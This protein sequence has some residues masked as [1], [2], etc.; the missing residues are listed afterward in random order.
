MD[1]DTRNSQKE[2]SRTNLSSD[3][4]YK[5]PPG[6]RW[7]K[8]GEVCKINPRSPRDF[9]RSLDTPTTFIPMA[10]INE[11]TGTVTGPQ[12]VPY[13]RV[14]KGY[15]YF[16]EGDV[17]FAKITPCMQNGKHVIA[18]NLIDRIGFGTTEF[19]VLRPHN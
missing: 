4:P 7:V 10:A 2:E 3:G 5:L 11:K 1:G 13:Y 8:L 6:W 18:R 14:A 12:I 19:H 16:E 17:L 9:T 15:T